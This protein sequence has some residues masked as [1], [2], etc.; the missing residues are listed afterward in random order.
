MAREKYEIKESK[1]SFHFN[2]KAGN[3]EIIGSSESYTSKAACKEGIESVRKNAA[4]AKVEDQTVAGYTAEACPKFEVFTDKAREFRFRLKATN[5][6]IILASEGYAVRAGCMN[7]IESV[8]ASAPD[9]EVT[10]G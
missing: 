10:G 3:G 5:G 6:Q 7:G 1:G 4:V 2:L 9:A 8:R